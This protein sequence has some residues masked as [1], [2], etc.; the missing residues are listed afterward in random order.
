MTDPYKNFAELARNEIEGVDY[1]ISFVA[2]GN[3]LLLIAAPHAG[4]I[5]VGT[6]SISE[7]IAGDDHSL[8]QFESHK[9]VD[10]NY[11]SLH[12]TSH[13]FDEPICI[14]AVESHDFVV[15]IHGCHNSEEIVF[16]GGIHQKLIDNI[17]EEIRNIGIDVR[18]ENHRFPGRHR[19]NICNRGRS[20]MGVQVE[21]SE[22]LRQVGNYTKIV[23]AIRSSLEGI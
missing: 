5:E 7:L 2:R 20:G 6:S 23:S 22:P 12:I 8:Y 11:I 1:S 9:V 13:I 3:G 15:T 19:N 14:R 18:T 21:L 17:A 10:E 4:V 16:L